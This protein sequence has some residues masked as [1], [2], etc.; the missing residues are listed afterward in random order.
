[1]VT[2]TRTIYDLQAVV[3]KTVSRILVCNGMMAIHFT[4]GPPLFLAPT[5]GVGIV[6]QDVLCGDGAEIALAEL[7]LLSTE[8]VAF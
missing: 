5:A 3:G 1:M 8:G 7:G 2:Q 6:W 4:E